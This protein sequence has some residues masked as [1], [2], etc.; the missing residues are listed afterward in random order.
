MDQAYS[1]PTEAGKVFREGIMANPLILPNIPVGLAKIAENVRF[2]GNTTPS[3]PINWRFA[4]SIAALKGFEAAM[5]SLLMKKK[6]GEEP[7]EITV[8]TYVHRPH[9]FQSKNQQTHTH[10]KVITPSSSSCPPS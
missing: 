1:V 5:L 6:Y 7:F 9:Q 8:N 2:E 4:E 10:R 3:V